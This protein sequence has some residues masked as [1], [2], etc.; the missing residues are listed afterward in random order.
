MKKLI[1]ALAALLTAVLRFQSIAFAQK[2]DMDFALREQ[3]AY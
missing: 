2:T 1:I 3:T